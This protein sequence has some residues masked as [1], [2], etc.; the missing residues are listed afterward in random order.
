MR[1]LFRRAPLDPVERRLQEIARQGSHLAGLANA[2]AFFMVLLFSL[3]SLVSLNADAL[4][5]AQDRWQ[6][7]Q[8]VDVP[9]IVSLF[10]STFLVVC[11]DVVMIYAAAVLRNLSAR[12]AP[13]SEKRKH[14]LHMY[15]AAAIESGSYAYMSFKYDMPVLWVVV[16]LILA[17][18]I[19]APMFSIYLSEARAIPVNAGDI[20]YEAELAS[21]T[22][23]IRDVVH[24]ANDHTRS[25]AQKMELYR[26]SAVM[27]PADRA[28]LDSMIGVVERRH[29]L[30]L[31]APEQPNAPTAPTRPPTGPGSPATQP[32]A[33]PQEEP[34]PG[35]IVR[36]PQPGKKPAAARAHTS[37][38]RTPKRAAAASVE[39][40][41]R[42]VWREGMSVTELERGAGVSRS[43]AHKWRRVLAAE[44]LN[45]PSDG[46]GS[47]ETP[48]T[49]RA[50]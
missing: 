50:Q 42:G 49:Q 21:G 12:R 47:G 11:M 14:Y 31:G 18:A 38:V 8:Q 29:E 3:G 32:P 28:R 33:R 37:R 40:K 1:S 23:V 46:S 2:C 34:A 7:G 22:G 35:R 16:A 41:V 9:S 15:V 44:G 30:L 25:L 10:V 17:R 24:E 45:Q 5:K 48:S 36:L 13:F 26:A 27:V 19:A 39:A 43:T 20:M 4:Q 6:H